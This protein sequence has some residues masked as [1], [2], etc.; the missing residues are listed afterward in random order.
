MDCSSTPLENLQLVIKLLKSQEI[1]T[2]SA[3][4]EKLEMPENTDHEKNTVVICTWYV[5]PFPLKNFSGNQGISFLYSLLTYIHI[6]SFLSL[7]TF[8]WQFG[9][10]VNTYLIQRSA[11]KSSTNQTIIR[12]WPNLVCNLMNKIDFFLW[13]FEKELFWNNLFLFL[14]VNN[15]NCRGSQSNLKWIS[16]NVF[17]F[18]FLS[19]FDLRTAFFQIMLFYFP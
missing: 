14:G 8:F 13:N 3:G 9:S 7:S 1:K 16:L 2:L 18:V 12:K 11:C 4:S 19:D 17:F 6:K 5:L 10:L 15:G